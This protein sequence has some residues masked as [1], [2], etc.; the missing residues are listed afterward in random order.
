MAC[1]DPK[2]FVPRRSA[3]EAREEFRSALRH[4]LLR[5]GVTFFL[6]SDVPQYGPLW[7]ESPPPE[8]VD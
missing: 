5:R 8:K 3:E 4:C 1:L 7:A 2:A 6:D